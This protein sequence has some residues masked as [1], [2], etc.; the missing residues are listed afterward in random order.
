MRQVPR[1]AQGL[2]VIS[3]RNPRGRRVRRLEID[4]EE[5][6]LFRVPGEHAAVL[7]DQGLERVEVE[8]RQFLGVGAGVGIVCDGEGARV[9]LHPDVC[10]DAG[11]AGAERGEERA[12][13][14]VVVV[15][16]ARHRGYVGVGVGWEG[17]EG[18]AFAG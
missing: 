15:R 10:F 13:A 12:R 17:D 5:R 16:V 2:Q 8:V 9:A 1:V 6:G 3:Q 4:E 18:V 11:A 7:V 14:L